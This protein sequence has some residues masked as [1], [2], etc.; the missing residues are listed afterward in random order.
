MNN[1]L[2][3][4]S[5]IP[6]GVPKQTV[7]INPVI[8]HPEFRSVP[9]ELSITMPVQ[10]RGLPIILLSHGDGP[11]LYLP[12]KDGYTPLANFY[13]EQGFVVIQ[14]THANSKV[15]G[16]AHSEAGAPLFWHMRVLE[17]K[18]ILDSLSIIERITPLLAGRLDHQR[19]AAVGHSMGGQTIGML[20]GAR[21]TNPANAQEIDV[22]VLEPRVKA[23]V[24]LAPPG[25]GGEE[26][27]AFAKENFP[28]LNPDYS[29]LTTQSLCVVGSE[30]LNPFMTVRG[31][32]WYRAAYE[33]G[34]GCEY[35][36]SLTGGQHGLGGIAGYDAKETAD[37][38][39][40]RLAIVQRLTA[41]YLK[42]ALYED[43]PSWRDA[44]QVLLTKASHLA[45]LET[46][47][48]K[49]VLEFSNTQEPAR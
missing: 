3:V 14:P 32:E 38:D 33:H 40:D 18:H 27:S 5:Q 15:A 13:A 39:P 24:L 36:L 29:Y 23:G 48:S 20:L 2:K 19:I 26:L 6:L 8:L 35:L 34:P 44:C 11:S 4:A 42:T 12:S 28:E 21:L 30:D 17:M 22:N 41:A 25:N 1:L 10:G 46:K 9:L 16:L 7:V 37:E 31:P 49:D 45:R 47:L 43:D